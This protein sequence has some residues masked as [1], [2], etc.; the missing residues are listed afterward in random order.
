MKKKIIRYCIGFIMCVSLLLGVKVEPIH[1]ASNGFQVSGTILY[2]GNGN[3]F[4][5][6]GVNYP[7]AWFSSEYK[8]AIPAIANKGFNCVRIVVS[9]GQKWSKTSYNE[10]DELISTC[11]Q[12]HLVAI[13]EVHDAT[14][15]DDTYSLDQ[16]VNYWIEM[17]ALL[18]QNESYVIVNIANE[19]YGTWDDGTSWK[20]GYISAIRKLREAGINNTLIVDCA[21]WGQY[22]QVIFDHGTSVLQADTQNNTMFSI[23]MYEYAGGNSNTVKN[24]MDQ[25]LNKNLCLTIGE[26]GGYHTNGDVDEDEIMRYGNSKNVGWIAWSWKGNNSDLN[27]LDL[28]Y[29][30]EG[31]NL[32]EFG[33]RVIYGTDGIQQTSKVCSIFTSNS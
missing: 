3:E 6:R 15:A 18:Q 21:G 23:H 10:L 29:D 8:T 26:F 28:S 7:H 13:L 24:N 19:W 32:T 5:M 1:A 12:N 17:K 30:W 25:V 11:K 20:N 33:N 9:N 22:P 16:A 31:N 4:V 14:G 2:D 27:Y